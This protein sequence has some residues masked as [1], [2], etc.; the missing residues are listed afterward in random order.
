VDNPRALLRTGSWVR[1]LPA[2]NAHSW[3]GRER[4]VASFEQLVTLIGAGLARQ[5]VS[6][7]SDMWQPYLTVI[8]A[9]CSQAIHSLDRFHIVAKKNT[10]LDQVRAGEPRRLARVSRRV[11][12]IL[13][14]YRARTPGAAVWMER[15]IDTVAEAVSRNFSY[16][17]PYPVVNERSTGARLIDVDG[18]DYIDFAYAPASSAL[19]TS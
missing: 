19:L 3:I 13:A 16:H 12:A 5:I 11:N 10:A 17:I 4:T 9:R 8:R 6:V 2:S 14:Q 7:C 15:S 18:N 1:Y